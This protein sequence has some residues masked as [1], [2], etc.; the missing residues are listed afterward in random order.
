MFNT[1]APTGFVM[2][3]YLRPWKLMTLAL[4]L[5]VPGRD[6]PSRLIIG[7]SA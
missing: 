6:V 2:Q 5:Q 4:G 7:P 3:E 1:A